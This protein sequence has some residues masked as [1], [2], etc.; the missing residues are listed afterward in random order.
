MELDFYFKEARNDVKIFSYVGTYVGII[1]RR[2]VYG[3]IFK[4]KTV[5]LRW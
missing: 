2:W 4:I 3:E 1:N 5:K